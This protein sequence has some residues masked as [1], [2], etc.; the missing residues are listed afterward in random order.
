MSKSD[1]S[2]QHDAARGLLWPARPPTSAGRSSGTAFPEGHVEIDSADHARGVVAAKA[3][4]LAGR[5]QYRWHG[6]AGHGG[7]W[8]V[9]ELEK[10]FGVGVTDGFGICLVNESQ[11]SF[12]EGYNATLAAEVNRRHGE[13]AFEEVFAESRRQSEEALGDARQ[14]WLDRHAEA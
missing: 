2:E 7:H 6:H 10:R 13:G 4:I 12:D 14:A 1:A 3:D 8:V 9:N 11:A 5:L